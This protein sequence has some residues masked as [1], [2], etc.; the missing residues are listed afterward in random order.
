MLKMSF[1]RSV[2]EGFVLGKP[3]TAD[4]NN[5]AAIEVV[6]IAVLVY[7]LEIAFQL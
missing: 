1:V 6:F 4:G 3:A 7:E 2:A 5:L